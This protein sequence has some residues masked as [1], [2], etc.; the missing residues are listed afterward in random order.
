MKARVIDPRKVDLVLQLLIQLTDEPAEGVGILVATYM[1]ISDQF[2]LDKPT[3][4]KLASEIS[5]MILCATSIPTDQ[6][7]ATNAIN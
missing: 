7:A 3:K 5:E 6:P 1:E 4:E 2:R